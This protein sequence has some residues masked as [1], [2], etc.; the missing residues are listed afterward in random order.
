VASAV[1]AYNRETNGFLIGVNGSRKK[2]E[3]AI[4]KAAYPLQTEERKPSSVSHGNLKAFDRARSTVQN[5]YV[6][7]DLLGGF[8][9]HTGADGKAD[10]SDLDIDYIKDE[11]Q[12]INRTNGKGTIES[13][14]E[15]VVAIRKRRYS[16]PHEIAWTWRKYHKKIGCTMAIKEHIGY[17]FTMGAYWVSMEPSE[18]NALV[19]YK[20]CEEAR[21]SIPWYSDL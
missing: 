1:E 2:R 3:V 8:H 21:I 15:L 6:G 5:L 7:L 4:L 16:T 11:V 18:K 10:L 17:D 9:S 19:H 12:H 13:W 20:D 14:L